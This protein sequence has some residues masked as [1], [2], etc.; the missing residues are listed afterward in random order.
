MP[1]PRQKFKEMFEYLKKEKGLFGQYHDWNDYLKKT[2][3]AQ[4]GKTIEESIKNQQVKNEEEPPKERFE[5]SLPPKE[6]EQF[7]K[8]FGD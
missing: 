1:I 5:D 7:L 6:R 2:E 3:P 4:E 8:M